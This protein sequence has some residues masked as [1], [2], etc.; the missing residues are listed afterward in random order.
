MNWSVG[1]LLMRRRPADHNRTRISCH[2][3]SGTDKH[4]ATFVRA[5]LA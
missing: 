2:A 3:K 4:F 5:E 1:V